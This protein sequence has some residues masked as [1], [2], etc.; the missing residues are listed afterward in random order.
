[1][2]TPQT[3]LLFQRAAHSPCNAGDLRPLD[4]LQ[5]RGGS[6]LEPPAIPGG[7][8]PRT[9]CSEPPPC[10]SGRLR[11][12]NS[13]QFWEAAPPGP[14]AMLG[15]YARWTPCNTRVLHPPDPLQYHNRDPRNIFRVQK[16]TWG[17]TASVFSNPIYCDGDQWACLGS[18]KTPNRVR[19]NTWRAPI[20]SKKTLG[21]SVKSDPNEC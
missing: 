12:P 20:G 9:P 3:P 18:K 11:P 13:L 16:N 14:P 19:K 2:A 17:C 1:M 21:P 7:C 15:Y 6:A 4:R 5:F 10:N 8:A